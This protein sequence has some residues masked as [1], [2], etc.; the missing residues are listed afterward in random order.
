MGLIRRTR[1]GRHVSLGA[2]TL[3][4]RY[5]HCD[6]Q[7]LDRHVSGHHATF[8]FDDGT[9]WLRT[10]DTTNATLV[11]G[12][13]QP[14]GARIRVKADTTLQFGTPSELWEVVHDTAPAL[15][16]MPSDSEPVSITGDRWS[17]PGGGPLLVRRGDRWLREDGSGTR[18][19]EDGE[20]IETEHEVWVVLMP[21]SWRGGSSHTLA[22][23]D[24]HVELVLEVS[25]D[26]ER[27]HRCS[28][29]LGGAQH[30]LSVRR[31]SHLLLELAD[32][33]QHGTSE[34]WVEDIA[35]RRRLGLSTSQLYLHTHRAQAQLRAAGLPEDRCVLETRGQRGAR[36][37]RLNVTVDV[38]TLETD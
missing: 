9:W 4:G 30:E 27:I 23:D 18:R 31:H 33:K 26:G 17:A 19:V 10:Q 38:R 35:V 14:G 16:L 15:V 28:L 20:V 21:A 13:A 25:Q 8:V 5:P 6:L 32:A 7:L 12:S 11:D 22:S 37:L 29:V 36:Q 34:G 3:V 24:D 1:D 2:R